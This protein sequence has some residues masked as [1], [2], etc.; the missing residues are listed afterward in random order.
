MLKNR[1][2]IYLCSQLQ[3]HWINNYF[4]KG[5]DSQHS[6]CC[7]AGLVVLLLFPETSRAEIPYRARHQRR[8]AQVLSGLRGTGYSL[9][10]QEFFQDLIWLRMVGW[11]GWST[12]QAYAAT[13]NRAQSVFSPSLLDCITSGTCPKRDSVW[14]L[15]VEDL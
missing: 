15:G 8:A 4:S 1:K 9:Q 7:A 13:K 5:T 14:Q 10:L 11:Q 12:S 3:C 2:K 6:G